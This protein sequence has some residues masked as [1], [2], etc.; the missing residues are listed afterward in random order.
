LIEGET[1]MQV[2]KV[3]LGGHGSLLLVAIV[4]LFALYLYS[5][6]ADN[7][8]LASIVIGLMTAFA[9]HLP[10]GSGAGSGAGSPS[11]P[12]NPPE[13]AP[14]AGFPELREQKEEVEK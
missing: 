2:P 6:H 11:L 8:T 13:V 5:Q 10:G 7:A 9:A 3:D 12:V 4:F 14:V 1:A